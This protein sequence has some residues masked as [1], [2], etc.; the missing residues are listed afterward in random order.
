MEYALGKEA[1]KAATRATIRKLA[2]LRE[3]IAETS[4]GENNRRRNPVMYKGDFNRLI[5][6]LDVLN[7]K[8]DPAF[9][10][11]TRTIVE[12]YR[13][14]RTDLRIEMDGASIVIERI[15]SQNTENTRK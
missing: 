14:Y 4:R 9:I 1:Y 3:V 12:A 15:Q 5:G 8:D 10:G 11:I 7:I 13:K 6:M 2:L